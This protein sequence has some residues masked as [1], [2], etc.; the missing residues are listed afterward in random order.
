MEN[1]EKFRGQTNGIILFILLGGD[2][3][4]DELKDII[5]K[6]FSL[7]KI[8]TLY[9]I[10]AR[11]KNQGHISEYRASS[12]DGS[13][14]KY[15]KITELGK[16][17]YEEEFSNLFLGVESIVV[18]QP[19][20][21][22]KVENS[23]IDISQETISE[24]EDVYL[25]YIKK[26]ENLKNEDEFIDF[27]V[28]E[29]KN[30]VENTVLV[31]DAVNEETPPLFVQDNDVS[32]EKEI[33]LDSVVSSNYEY[34]SVLN[35]LFPKS[36]GYDPKVYENIQSAT[37]QDGEQT[38]TVQQE[39]T[40]DLDS[41][42]EISEREKIKIRTSIDTNR[43]QGAKILA[44]KLRFHTA[45]IVF[46]IA[47]L[48]FL[49]GS[50]A[51]LG[52]AKFNSS[53]FITVLVVF[54]SVVAITGIVYLIKFNY[55]VKDLPKLINTMEIAIILA[56]G[57]IIISICVASIGGI[58]LY[59]T[60]EVFSSIILPALMASNIPVYVL[61]SHFLSKLDYYQAI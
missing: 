35:K 30:E 40:T 51:L 19:E 48:E 38:T 4:T 47:I 14:R 32:Y 13:R 50:F 39:N 27:S 9:S 7:V 58:D 23:P 5:D 12:K 28:L 42:F 37:E 55:S 60:S 26:A 56:I 61:I 3:H 52:S 49:V 6:N 20:N 43:Y 10:I 15:Y 25:K 18:S 24:E 57:I 1:N 45:I 36:K 8:G 22:E 53:A 33:D 46:I 31:E 11:M 16:K 41:L 44:S 17:F 29:E 59:N 21:E 34:K 2:R 54:G